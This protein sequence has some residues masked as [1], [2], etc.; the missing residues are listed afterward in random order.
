LQCCCQL[1]AGGP[2]T[3]V[4][5]LVNLEEVVL[6]VLVPVS[7]SS[8]LVSR[9]YSCSYRSRL[10]L[11]YLG[12]PYERFYQYLGNTRRCMSQYTTVISFEIA[13]SHTLSGLDEGE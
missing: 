7:T 4:G 5:V 2:A 13:P 10:L 6:E 1:D 3:V 8:S 12:L 11:Y 9:S